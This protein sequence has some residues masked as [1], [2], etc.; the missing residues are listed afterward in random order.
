MWR[1]PRAE[2]ED[3]FEYSY[4][5]EIDYGLVAPVIYL[6]DDEIE[7]DAVILDVDGDPLLASFRVP[8]PFGFQLP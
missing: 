3:P 6:E 1:Y 8:F 5:Y 2:G 7:C 4:D